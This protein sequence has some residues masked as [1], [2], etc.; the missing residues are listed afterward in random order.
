[1]SLTKQEVRRKSDSPRFYIRNEGHNAFLF[2]PSDSRLHVSYHS[3]GA[4]FRQCLTPR[5]NG[6]SEGALQVSELLEQISSV[7]PGRCLPKLW[8]NS[9]SSKTGVSGMSEML[10]FEKKVRKGFNAGRLVLVGGPDS[11]VSSRRCQ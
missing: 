7:G 1:M 9:R 5:T 10:C 11:P 6:W 8:S 3:D 4:A 2:G